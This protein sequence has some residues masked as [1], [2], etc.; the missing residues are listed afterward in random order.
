MR[1]PHLLLILAG[2][3]IFSG[4]GGQR[5]RGELVV[6]LLK[7]PDSEPDSKTKLV[8]APLE[9]TQGI[10]RGAMNDATFWKIDMLPRLHQRGVHILNPDRWRE[11]HL[12]LEDRSPPEITAQKIVCS[13]NVYLKGIEPAQ[14]QLVLSTLGEAIHAC[15]SKPMLEPWDADIREMEQLLART[16]PLSPK[17]E[18]VQALLKDLQ[19]GRTAELDQ[20]RYIHVVAKLARE[21]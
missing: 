20:H 12:L 9:A 10:I 4:C 19:E 14:A 1:T 3:L 17:A 5:T 8:C 6:S 2:A 15:L 16:D 13:Y 18:Q 21:P 7:R 11:D